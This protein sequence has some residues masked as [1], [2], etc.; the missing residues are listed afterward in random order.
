MRIDWVRG[1][2]G[3]NEGLI[4]KK[5]NKEAAIRFVQLGRNQKHERGKAKVERP[6]KALC[7]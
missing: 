3:R 1:S 6:P 5:L 4:S 2:L 7:K